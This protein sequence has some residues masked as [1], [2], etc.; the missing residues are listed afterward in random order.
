M[1]FYVPLSR[2]V[3]PSL[4]EQEIKNKEPL[5]HDIIHLISQIQYGEA[6]HFLKTSIFTDRKENIKN[7]ISGDFF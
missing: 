7:L 3:R 5:Q 4:M 6:H 2:K 1:S